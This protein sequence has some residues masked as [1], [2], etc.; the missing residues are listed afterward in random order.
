MLGAIP[1]AVPAPLLRSVLG[2]EHHARDIVLISTSVPGLVDLLPLVGL[3]PLL[4]GL[5]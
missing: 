2:E 3:L 1:A 5:N 4:P